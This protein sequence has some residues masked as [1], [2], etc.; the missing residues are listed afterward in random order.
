MVNTM[1]YSVQILEFHLRGQIRNGKRFH[2]ELNK[3]LLFSFFWRLKVCVNV[4]VELIYKKTQDIA[5][6]CLN[7]NPKIIDF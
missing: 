6:N 5:I 7:R 3:Y 4:F 2:L 1:E